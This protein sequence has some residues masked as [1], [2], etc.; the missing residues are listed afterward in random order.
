MFN[1]TTFAADWIDMMGDSY[2]EYCKMLDDCNALPYD[3][4]DYMD[5]YPSYDE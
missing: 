5:T 3:D 1:N 2:Q 4:E